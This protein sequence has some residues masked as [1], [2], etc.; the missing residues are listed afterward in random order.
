MQVSRRKEF[1]HVLLSSRKVSTLRV[2]GYLSI[3]ISLITVFILHGCTV[4]PC[5]N[6]TVLQRSAR[7]NPRLVYVQQD[8]VAK[9]VLSVLQC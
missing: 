3:S 4:N 8:T 5:T 6:T 7:L 2:P 9:H 1:S